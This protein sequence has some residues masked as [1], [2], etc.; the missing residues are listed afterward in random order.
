MAINM[1]S[2]AICGQPFN[3][4]K[5]VILTIIIVIMIII[6][7]IIMIITTIKVVKAQ[8]S[9]ASSVVFLGGPAVTLLRITNK[10]PTCHNDEF[11]TVHGVLCSRSHKLLRAM[12]GLGSW[13]CKASHA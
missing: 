9:F 4:S 6:R 8:G 13:C 11:N 5:G 10:H 12:Y 2:N 7:I 1:Q 3:N